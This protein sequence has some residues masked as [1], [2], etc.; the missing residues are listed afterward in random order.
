MSV[1]VS[2]D[3]LSAWR[4]PR[5][6]TQPHAEHTAGD[7]DMQHA[8]DVEEAEA[9]HMLNPLM[10]QLHSHM[11][12]LRKSWLF[13]HQPHSFRSGSET[14][15]TWAEMWGK[16]VNSQGERRGEGLALPS[17]GETAAS[18]TSPVSSDAAR[19]PQTSEEKQ[20]THQK[21]NTSHNQ[22]VKWNEDSLPQHHQ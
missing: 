4:H 18:G 10:Q 6:R 20:H 3:V 22:H 17:P 19:S 21:P 1:C 2:K 14:G 13:L 8:E 15:K 16:P 12:Q 9:L 11:L 7:A 5:A